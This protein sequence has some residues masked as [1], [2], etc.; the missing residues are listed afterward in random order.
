M[1]YVASRALFVAGLLVV[2]AFRFA[3]AQETATAKEKLDYYRAK[4][5]TLRLAPA[6]D[7]SEAFAFHPEPLTTFE[8]PVSQVWDGYTFVWTDR[9]RPAAALK[10]YYHSINKRWGRT[11]VSLSTELIELQTGDEKLWTPAEA[12]LSFALL[13]EGPQPASD[14][15]RRL[16]Q[17]R[18]IAR[19]F[20]MVD[21]WG[22]KDPTDWQLRLLPTPLYRY[23][24]PELGVVDGALFGYVVSS[25]EA[26]VLL[27][28]RQAEGD[29]EPAWH[30]GVA[31]FT[32]F[33]VTASL[34][35]KQTAHFPRLEAWPPTGVYFHD[36][37]EMP[38]YPFPLRGT[39]EPSP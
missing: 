30:Y 25:P 38:D 35:N 23:E 14:A 31:R 4:L 2:M 6:E 28:L 9:G 39:D 3:A 5:E 15:R 22:L 29:D 21:R 7:R 20:T 8:N 1:L 34:D 36:P 37:V 10:C 18:D 17:M 32:R 33:E 27:E 26:L 16:T 19:R 13:P 12:G 11:F 24:S